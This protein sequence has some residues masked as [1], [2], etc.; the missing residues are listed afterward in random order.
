MVTC[1]MCGT[2]AKV[3]DAIVEGTILSVCT[4]CAKFGKVV[5]LNK[6]EP[7]VR[8]VQAAKAAAV[9][10]I[11][12]EFAKQIKKAREQKDLTQE[13]L[14]KAIAEKESVIHN[15]E[16]GNLKPSFKLA[17][18]LEQFLGMILIETPED[19]EDQQRE[20]KDFN[21]TDPSLTIGDLLHKKK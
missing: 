17:K 1:E 19:E 9:E 18:K 14:A 5:Q 7:V 4:N 8:M 10:E 11:V 13:K 3:S 2:E 16:S 20:S 21:L 12:P 6:P 15:V